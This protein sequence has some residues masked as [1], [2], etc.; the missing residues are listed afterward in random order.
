M[1]LE[2]TKTNSNTLAAFLKKRDEYIFR[3]RSFRLTNLIPKLIFLQIESNFSKA[4]IKKA[5]SILRIYPHQV[6]DKLDK[7]S[8]KFKPDFFPEKR[9]Q[10]FTLLY[11]M[12]IM[13]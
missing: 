8:V 5:V 10:K 2:P 13:P 1:L 7:S 6:G 3:K 9:T 12:F 4:F 11:L